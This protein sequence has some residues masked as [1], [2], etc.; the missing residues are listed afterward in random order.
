[1]NEIARVALETA[2]PLYVDPYREIRGMGALVLVDPISNNTVAAGM[3]SSARIDDAVERRKRV[4][5]L[6]FDVARVTPLER[7]HRHGHRGALLLTENRALAEA[8]DR[9]F[10]DRGWQSLLVEDEALSL[11]APPSWLRALLSTATLVV[12][13]GCGTAAR[14]ENVVSW[15]DSPIL[16]VALSGSIEQSTRRALEQLA[17]LQV[18]PADDQSGYGE[19]I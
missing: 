7:Q 11:T 1:M 3:I 19:G 13:T 5:S 8:L 12:A 14:T 10:F 6:S 9:A 4:A 15:G 17:A 16:D 2:S 18:V